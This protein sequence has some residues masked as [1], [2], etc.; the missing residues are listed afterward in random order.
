MTVSSRPLRERSAGR[1]RRGRRRRHHE[2]GRA[3]PR[4]LLCALRRATPCW[5]KRSI[6]PAATARPESLS[7]APAPGARGHAFRAL[8]EGYL[9][10]PPGARKRL[11]RGGTGLRDAASVAEVAKP[12]R[13]ACAGCWP[14]CSE[15]CR[16]ARRP[17]TPGDRLP[18]GRRA[19][20][21]RA[22]WHN[23]EGKALLAAS[24]KPLLAQYDAPSPD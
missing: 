12:R 16:R 10:E 5:P 13:S 2:G 3:D 6:A 4:R 14:R 1:F 21:W 9:S 20:S 15:R 11:R 7:A 24:R 22:P 18:T 19:C 23:A 8:V 17:I